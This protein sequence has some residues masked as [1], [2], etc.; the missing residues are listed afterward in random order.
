MLKSTRVGYIFIAIFVI[1]LGI[2]IWLGNISNTSNELIAQTNSSSSLV[3]DTRIPAVT[4]ASVTIGQTIIPVELAT[5]T[6]ALQKGLSGR[7]SLDSQSGMLFIFAKPDKYRFWMPDMLFP[8]DI[9]WINDGKVVDIS[10][11]VSNKFDPTDPN[12]YTPSQPVQYV[13]EVNAGFAA[14][15][16]IQIGDT[17][18]LNGI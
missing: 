3:A 4:T 17:T 18:I 14:S 15:K 9:I 1:L 5:S 2:W 13:L 12:F 16:R 6:A 8:L 7:I 11:N 10:E